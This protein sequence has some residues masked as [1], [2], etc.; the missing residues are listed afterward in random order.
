VNITIIE[1]FDC[2]T[3][4]AT[5]PVVAHCIG[6]KTKEDK[7][8]DYDVTQLKSSCLTAIAFIAA[9]AAALGLMFQFVG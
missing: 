5:F 4:D 9:S 1:D 7:M 8:T 6:R 2:L 3:A